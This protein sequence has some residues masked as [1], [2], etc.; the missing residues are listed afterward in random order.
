MAK[1]LLGNAK[2][3]K[4]AIIA[5][6]LF[7]GYIA[8]QTVITQLPKIPEMI[9]KAYVGNFGL[10]QVAAGLLIYGAFVLMSKY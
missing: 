5:A 3:E 4:Y 8:L 9:T 2:N 6:M 1:H 7:L 10:V